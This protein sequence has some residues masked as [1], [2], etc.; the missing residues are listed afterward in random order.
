MDEKETID[1]IVLGLPWKTSEDD[2]K[3]YFEEFGEVLMVQVNYPKNILTFK[4]I[5]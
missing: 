4:Q 3:K 1:L 2:V 5:F